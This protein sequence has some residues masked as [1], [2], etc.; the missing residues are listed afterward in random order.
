MSGQQI[1]FQCFA[2]INYKNREDAA[3]AISQLNGFAYDHLLLDVE[4][5]K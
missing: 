3:S 4:W 1:I 5:A 2:F